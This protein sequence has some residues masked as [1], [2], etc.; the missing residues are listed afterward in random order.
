[1]PVELGAWACIA[2]AA[3][4]MIGGL[5]R[6]PDR[7]S[8]RW[9]AGLYLLGAL[10]FLFI[11]N[12]LA[13]ALFTGLGAWLAP[14]LTPRRGDRIHFRAGAAGWIAGLAVG[15]WWTVKMG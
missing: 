2:T 3:L 14:F 15:I 5:I 10:G 1:M 7:H 13:L 4:G 8:G 12:G 9:L 11:E 6:P